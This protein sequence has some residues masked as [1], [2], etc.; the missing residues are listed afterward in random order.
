MDKQNLERI[1]NFS[2]KYSEKYWNIRTS[3]FWNIWML[4]FRIIGVL[5]QKN[6]YWYNILNVRM[7]TKIFKQKI[8]NLNKI[9][10][11]QLNKSSNE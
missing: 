3:E 8:I 10:Y 5:E 2:N 11:K 7:K 4:D 1:S 6:I 9:F